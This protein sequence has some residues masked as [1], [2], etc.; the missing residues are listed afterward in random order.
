MV[1]SCPRYTLRLQSRDLVR[2]YILTCVILP[3]A[4]DRA[5]VLNA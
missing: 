3:G 4:L 1:H 2:N 5:H